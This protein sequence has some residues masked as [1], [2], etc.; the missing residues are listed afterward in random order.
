MTLDATTVLLEPP[1]KSSTE[2]P[3]AMPS[4]SRDTNPAKAAAR[5]EALE[6][7]RALIP[8]NT[9]VC[10]Q[11]ASGSTDI[12][13]SKEQFLAAVADAQYLG[14]GLMSDVFAIQIDGKVSALKF[15]FGTTSRGAPREYAIGNLESEHSWLQKLDAM[16]GRVQIEESKWPF[17]R[18]DGV[19]LIQSEG[20]ATPLKMEAILEQYMPYPTLRDMIQ[21]GMDLS[22][23]KERCHELL[24]TIYEKF[25]LAVWDYPVDNIFVFPDGRFGFFDLP[26]LVDDKN[27][28]PLDQAIEAFDK[29]IDLAH[30]AWLDRQQLDHKSP[31]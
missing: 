19:V 8:E 23:A 22:E 1:I 18:L 27:C 28:F 4:V 15:A 10:F 31:G 21:R 20:E 6:A 9:S 16:K 26:S 25:G 30:A 17:P 11:F 5:I 29:A 13:M 7:L 14:H 24:H 12:T 2:Q 3:F